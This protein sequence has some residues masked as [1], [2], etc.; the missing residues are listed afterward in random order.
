M[1]SSLE[2]FLFKSMAAHLF[3]DLADPYPRFTCCHG[4]HLGALLWAQRMNQFAMFLKLTLWDMWSMIKSNQGKLGCKYLT[5]RC[6]GYVLYFVMYT[7]FLWISECLE[8]SSCLWFVIPCPYHS[9]IV[10]ATS[11]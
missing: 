7:G 6:Y 1:T 5:R 3:S 10:T 2:L 4:E 11:S 8:Y 9:D